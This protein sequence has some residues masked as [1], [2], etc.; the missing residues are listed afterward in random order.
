MRATTVAKA[1]AL[2]EGIADYLAAVR[3]PPGSP[4]SLEAVRLFADREAHRIAYVR[5]EGM[6]V[7]NSHVVGAAI[8]TPV[9]IYRPT[10]AGAQPAILYFHGG[11]F[12]TGSIES[13]DCFATALA[14][15]SGATVISVHYARL[16]E[17]TPC[18][19][20]EQCHDALNWAVRMA[21]ELRIDPAR[22]AVA[23]DS[24]GAFLA[25]HLTLRVRDLGGPA[26]SCQLLCYGVF[27][28]D[29]AR[30]AYATARDP[31]LTRAIIEAMI[32]TYRTCESRDGARLSAPLRVKDLSGMPPTILLGA[33]Y[34]AVLAEG[35]EYAVRLRAA[36]IA[37]DERVAPGMCH[38]FLRAVRFSQPA[39][40]E[41][42]WLGTA[43]RNYL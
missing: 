12:T 1:P 43:L 38:G 15:A 9:R 32:A 27:D 35:R 37:V 42:Q 31:V 39:R 41:M 19:T 28:L 29:P 13:Y 36:G 5:P 22:I 21:G 34:D 11:G 26:L 4:P 7:V 25:T 33:E 6:T 20:L 24:A 3:R 17:S 40:D 14:E 18:A 30:E 2:A 10:G 8:E 16:P 23:G